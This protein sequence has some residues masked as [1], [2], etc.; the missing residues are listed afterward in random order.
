VP[1]HLGRRDVV[2]QDGALDQPVG[3]VVGVVDDWAGAIWS[4]VQSVGGQI[5]Q[6][7][8]PVRH[9]HPDLGDIGELLEHGFPHRVQRLLQGE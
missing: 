2:A 9:R 6:E 1:G 4:V 7:V 8:V 3:A 5:L